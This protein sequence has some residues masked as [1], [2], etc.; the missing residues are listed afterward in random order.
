[1]HGLYGVGCLG[2]SPIIRVSLH[3][4]NCYSLWHR[5]RSLTHTEM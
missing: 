4:G 3:V 2:M 1:M 5:T